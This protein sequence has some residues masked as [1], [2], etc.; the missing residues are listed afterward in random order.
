MKHILHKKGGGMSY[1]KA[2]R[3]C[4]CGKIYHP[5]IDNITDNV[6]SECGSL[7]P[8]EIITGKWVKEKFVLSPWQKE[9]DEKASTE[10]KMDNL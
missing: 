3:C 4:D 9:K 7:E 1:Q 6:C 2:T 10:K 8:L 5:K